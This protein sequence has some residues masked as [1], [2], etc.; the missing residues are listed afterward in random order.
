M[1]FGKVDIRHVAFALVVAF[2]VYF[3]F[4]NITSEG[5]DQVGGGVVGGGEKI[6][7]LAAVRNRLDAQKKKAVELYQHY[8]QDRIVA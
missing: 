2:L 6:A 5:M 8:E 1:K 7:K 4:F 3:M